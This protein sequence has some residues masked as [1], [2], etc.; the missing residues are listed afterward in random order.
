M[1]DL[2]EDPV[3]RRRAKVLLWLQALASFSPPIS[4]NRSGYSITV[5]EWGWEGR[6]D[7]FTCVLSVTRQSTTIFDHELIRVV[8]PPLI[9]QGTENPNQAF[10]QVLFHL[11]QWKEGQT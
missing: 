6:N 2:P 11:I 4:F 3:E 10:R 7:V 9:D 8:N 5:H 1:A